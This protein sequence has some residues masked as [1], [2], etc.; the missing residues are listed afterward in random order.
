MRSLSLS[1][2]S[3]VTLARESRPIICPND[4]FERQLRV[5]QFCKYDIYQPSS[6]A[7]STT[8]EAVTETRQE[9][10]SYKAWKAERDVLLKRGEE[11]VNRAKFS[12]VASMAALFGKRR[13]EI[14]SEGKVEKS[15]EE[16]K[17]KESWDRVQRMEEEWNER[18]KKGIAVKD[19][20]DKPS[21]H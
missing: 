6:D 2:S 7:P 18:L 12:S 15:L 5:W 1:Y 11:D 8:T 3:A 10:P 13:R 21:D 16:G 20:D 14:D 9:K 17:R 19:E 4:G